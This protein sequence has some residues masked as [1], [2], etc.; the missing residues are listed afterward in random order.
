LRATGFGGA[1][2]IT[3][4]YSLDY[5]DAAGTGLTALLNGALEASAAA[6]GAVVADLGTGSLHK[7]SPA[8]TGH[9][10]DRR[11]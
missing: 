9:W 2:V 11:N 3:N 4:Y 1:I 8:L 5:S 7:P 6:Y 10:T